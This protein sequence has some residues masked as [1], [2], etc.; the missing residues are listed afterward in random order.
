MSTLFMAETGHATES[1]RHSIQAV[2]CV[3]GL[4]VCALSIGVRAEQVVTRTWVAKSGLHSIF[5]R[6]LV[7]LT[8][9][10][11]GPAT[12]LSRAVIELRDRAGNVAARTEG[13]LTARLPLQLDLKVADNAGLIQ[14]R[15]IVTVTNTRDELIA[16]LVTLEDIHPD[17]GLVSKINPPCGPGSGPGSPQ[18]SC[19]GWLILTSP[20]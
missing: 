10:E 16:P 9:F 14:L 13:D 15:A 17:L 19:P 7:R 2:C 1:R 8:V 3:I 18:F 12:V 6:H 11:A 5:N 4:A 20:Q